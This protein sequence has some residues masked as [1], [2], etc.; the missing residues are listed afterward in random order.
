MMRWTATLVSAVVVVFSATFIVAR[1]S[2][3]TAAAPQLRTASIVAGKPLRVRT[4]R[5]VAPLPR[6]HRVQSAAPATVPTVPLS[7]PPPAVP[8]PLQ[9]SPPPPPPA[10]SSTRP[11]PG[12]L[13]ARAVWLKFV[14]GAPASPRTGRC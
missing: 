4:L 5:G 7:P 3:G 8:P 2:A 9:A 13:C 6:L 14:G 10:S 12:A 1:V 11:P